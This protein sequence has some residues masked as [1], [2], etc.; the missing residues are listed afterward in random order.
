MPVT[1]ARPAASVQ[2][3]DL[4]GVFRSRMGHDRVCSTGFRVVFAILVLFLGTSCGAVADA[5]TSDPGPGNVAIAETPTVLPTST[6]APNI[7]TPTSTSVPSATPVATV[8]I[9][10][11]VVQG[12]DSE[13]SYSASVKAF[14]KGASTSAD[15]S[16]AEVAGDI[17]LYSL[18]W[19]IA[20]G[21]PSII[22]VNLSTLE[23][24]EKERDL[25]L[26]DHY[27]E[28]R[29]F[30]QATYVIRSVSPA[31][32]GKGTSNAGPGDSLTTNV[33]IKL[34]GDLTVRET[35]RP[36][37]W[38]GTA[39][40]DG[41]QLTGLVST[42]ITLSDFG[43]PAITLPFLEVEPVVTLEIKLVANRKPAG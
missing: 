33:P 28:S 36:I 4:P 5:P 39:T 3:P 42:T 35:V 13:A 2:H 30:P 34:E 11:F 20:Q 9:A 8:A 18:T 16:T 32:P 29:R 12:D 15:G 43:I 17:F 27:L 21:R 26:S 22:T 25:A 40:L 38:T 24:E 37:N 7:S 14:N 31:D 19:V 23:S 41:D 10:H 1:I 6:P